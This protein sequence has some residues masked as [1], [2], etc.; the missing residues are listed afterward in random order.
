MSSEEY[1]Y[2]RLNTYGLHLHISSRRIWQQWSCQIEWR[3]V[4][5][6]RSFGNKWLRFEKTA[7]HIPDSWSMKP[8]SDNWQDNDGFVFTK[9]NENVVSSLSLSLFFVRLLFTLL[10]VST[11]MIYS[12]RTNATDNLASRLTCTM[13]FVHELFFIRSSRGIL[14]LPCLSTWGSKQQWRLCYCSL[15]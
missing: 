8:S 13:T 15:W 11:L 5:C 7:F 6:S 12:N 3:V 4:F 2:T 9:D 1:A 10:T 14:T